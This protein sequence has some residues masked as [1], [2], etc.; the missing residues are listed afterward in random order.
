MTA[1]PETIIYYVRATDPASNEQNTS[2]CVGFAMAHAK[3]VEPR[4][5]GYR[6][7]AMSLPDLNDNDTAA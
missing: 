3:A 5:S 2:Q 6:D 7:V 4:M 1:T